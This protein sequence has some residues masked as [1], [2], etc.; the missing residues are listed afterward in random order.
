[1][2][3]KM[4]IDPEGPIYRMIK[5]QIENE[6]KEKIVPRPKKRLKIRL[7]PPKRNY[8]HVDATINGKSLRIYKKKLAP[9]VKTGYIEEI[10]KNIDDIIEK[11]I[12]EAMKKRSKIK[13]MLRPK[14][15]PILEP[16]VAEPM[17]QP[18]PEEEE[19]P[20]QTI[21]KIKITVN[22]PEAKKPVLQ[23]GAPLT[24]KGV[25]LA[26]KT[27]QEPG[28]K[29]I[30]M[31]TR[32]G[33]ITLNLKPEPKKEPE[34]KTGMLAGSMQLEPLIQM[35]GLMMNKPDEDEERPKVDG[36]KLPEV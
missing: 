15:E 4:N 27:S 16:L 14:R 10:P 13:I 5:E 32:H 24:P 22:R 31:K 23:K 18:M 21:R 2:E 1:M 6:Q 25:S 3:I 19:K 9:P 20:T 26:P 7:K 28:Q 11:K 36:V 8:E 35:F 12:H 30:M 17:L 29:H 33:T 34:I